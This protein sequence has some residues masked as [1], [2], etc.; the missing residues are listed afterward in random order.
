MHQTAAGESNC[1]TQGVT[2]FLCVG[3]GCIARA[4]EQPRGRPTARR[5]TSVHSPRRRWVHCGST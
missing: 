2:L 3:N 4:P 5:E 1:T